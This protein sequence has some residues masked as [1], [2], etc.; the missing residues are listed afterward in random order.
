MADPLVENFL[1]AVD[2]IQQEHQRAIK[3]T[4]R[5]SP[6]EER[7]LD[8]RCQGVKRSRYIRAGLFNYPTPRPRPII[9]QTNRET[10]AELSRIGH[11]LNQQTRV[12]H[13]AMK[14]GMTPALGNA[15]WEEL[16]ALRKLLKQIQVEISCPHDQ[17]VEDEEDE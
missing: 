11:N 13:E 16:N 1:E 10:Y 3:V 4:F 17:D 8:E 14:M 15:Y 6:V 9:P 5:I 2:E 12:M 7:L